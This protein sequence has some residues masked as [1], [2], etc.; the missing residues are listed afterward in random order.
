MINDGPMMVEFHRCVVSV[1]KLVARS[2]AL[3]DR[4]NLSL[5]YFL[6]PSVNLNSFNGGIL[7][8]DIMICL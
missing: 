2:N 6:V 4:M 8:H 7:E 5:Q 1:L 3:S